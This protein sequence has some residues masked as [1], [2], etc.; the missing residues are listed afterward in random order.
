MAVALKLSTGCRVFVTIMDLLMIFL[1]ARF[2]GPVTYRFHWPQTVECMA[3]M[4]EAS[5]V[6]FNPI[7]R[8]R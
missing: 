3:L 4:Y 6:Y 8:R 1:V 7:S 2:S 5:A